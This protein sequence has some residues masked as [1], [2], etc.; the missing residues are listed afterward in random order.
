MTTKQ[1]FERVSATVAF[2]AQEEQ[3]LALW[4][5]IDAFKVSVE[6][7]PESS[8]FSFYDGPPFPTGSPHYGNL[9]A[10]VLKDIVPRY[11]T[12][13][14]H[15]VERRFGWDTHGLPIELEVQKALGLNGPSEILE[16]GVAEFNEACR[17]RVMANTEV[18]EAITRRIGR[19]VDFEDDYKTMD[20]DF[21][22]SVWWV[23]K[24]LWDKGLVY[25]AFKVLP[26]S[27]GAATPLSNHE[28]NLGQYR[29]VEDPSITVRLEVTE[30]AGPVDAGDHLLIWT[31]TPWT[32]PSNLGVAVGP[33]IEYVRIE[34][35]LDDKDGRYWIAED[36]VSTYWDD[37]PEP[38]ARCK[39]HHMLGARYRPIFGYFEDRRDDGAFVVVA[40][41]ETSTE[42]GTGLVHMAP[43]Y[44]EADFDAFRAAGLDVIVD[45]V[46]DI[47]NF[48]DEVPE[49]AG[50]NVKAADAPLLELMKETGDLVRNE[51]AVH[52]YPFCWRT[53]TPLIYKA[54]PTWFV[55]VE[56]F[57]D[58]MAELNESIHWVPEHVG[59]GRF[60]NWLENARDWAISR[61]RF[62][63]SCL[64]VWE[65]DECEHSVCVGSV[66]ELEKHSGV[67]VDDLH[68]HIVDEVAFGC[69]ECDGTMRRTPEV[70]DVWFESGAM[71][72]GQNHYPF[73]NKGRFESRFP[74]D[75]IAEGLDQTR[76][77]FYTLVIHSTA[78]FDQVPFQNCVVNGMILAEDGRKMSKSLKNYPDPFELLDATGADALRAFLIDSPVVR[79]EP[80][81][82][83][84]R[85][86]REVVRTVLLPYWNAYSFFTTYAAAENLSAAD[87]A[88]APDASDRPEI[89]Q[90]ILSVLQSLVKRVNTEMEGYYLYNVIPPLI[91][92]VDDL[93]NWYIRRSR[94]RFWAARAEGES[95]SDDTVAAFATLYEV[96]VTFAKLMAPVLPF[97][98]ETMYQG[99]VVSQRIGEPGPLSVHH[100]DYPEADEGRIDTELERQMDAVRQAVSLGRGLRV[101]EGLKV[102]QPLAALTVVSHD[103]ALRAAIV[104]HAELIAEELNVKAVL[105][106]EDEASLAHLSVK[107]NFR[108]LGPRFG[109]EMKAA[110]AVIQAFDDTAVASLLD[111]G[112]VEVMDRQIGL[113]DVVVERQPRAGVAV[114]AG[115][116]LSVAIDTE[117]TDDLLV[118]GMAREVVKAVQALRRELGLDVS[119]RISLSWSSDDDRVNTAMAAHGAWVASETLATEIT[120][121][122][123]DE[124]ELT[125]SVTMRLRVNPAD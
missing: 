27:W 91:E 21:M 105:T 109:S 120:A 49:V 88:A 82:F 90:W 72:Y 8:E 65:C 2:P 48:T 114:A 125:E 68:K 111:G 41:D 26:Y 22:E 123:G 87:L 28:V 32:M 99:L 89:D 18:W 19:W 37:A 3:I 79:A 47:G 11:W 62:W 85:G 4:D 12:M 104:E 86:V 46:D 110:A 20:P 101:A 34:A 98:T 64:P 24:Q 70:L 67:R 117:L 80:L 122:D 77:W 83:T 113:E 108:A 52:S 92:F 100:E 118:E 13:R 102:R 61:N 106:S 124:I 9:L 39:G 1:P 103:D 50:M 96:L 53:D 107:P 60:G 33:D 84:E 54:I 25:K 121:G 94:R 16:Y 116:G 30:G 40:S 119:D 66:D 23:F 112:T 97:I 63:G 57:R 29:D 5:D 42:E 93:T 73:E 17:S 55:A 74:A 10:G 51:R 71:P 7:R 35:P 75:Y 76:G 36:L 38:T 31:T 43:A 95:A 78:I 6:Q 69:T 81:R 115:D 15:R 58:R 56:T 44:G 59:T 45:P 14:G